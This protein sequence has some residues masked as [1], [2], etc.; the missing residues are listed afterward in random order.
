LKTKTKKNL[1]KKKAYLS[2]E[3]MVTAI[4]TAQLVM[5]SKLKGTSI[6]GLGVAEEDAP[7][8]MEGRSRRRRR[9]AWEEE[10]DDLAW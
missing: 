9:S 10:E 4:H 2:P 6:N 7:E 3:V 8:E 1:M 5:G